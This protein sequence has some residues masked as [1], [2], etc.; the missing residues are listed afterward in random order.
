MPA[1]VKGL[2][3]N[4]ALPVKQIYVKEKKEENQKP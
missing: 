4:P 3:P 1:T 2:M